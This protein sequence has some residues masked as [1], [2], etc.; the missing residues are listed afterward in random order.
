[1]PIW[2]ASTEADGLRVFAD[3]VHLLTIHWTADDHWVEI[4]DEDGDPSKL[5]DL[6]D[7]I[8]STVKAIQWP[9]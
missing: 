8:P 2:R 9:K 1:M 4:Y 3:D 7:L 5:A 6:N